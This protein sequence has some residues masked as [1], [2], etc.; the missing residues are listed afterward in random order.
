MFGFKF[1]S[2]SLSRAKFPPCLY[3][4]DCW[5]NNPN[6]IEEDKVEPEIER[7]VYFSVY[8]AFLPLSHEVEDI[9]V[10]LTE[11]EDDLHDVAVGFVVGECEEGQK[12]QRAVNEP[13]DTLH[14]YHE[15]VGTDRCKIYV[16]IL[17][18]M[19]QSINVIYRV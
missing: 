1:V 6:S 2:L 18:S 8:K 14:A 3:D 19:L 16:N 5:Y 10:E 15:R 12:G 13:S 11:G 4:A 7:V 17:T 9:A